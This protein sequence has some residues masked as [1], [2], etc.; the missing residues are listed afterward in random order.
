MRTEPAGER[1]ETGSGNTDIS[2]RN[3]QLSAQEVQIGDIVRLE[4]L[5]LDCQGVE[6]GARRGGPVR[7]AEANARLIV[8]ESS[9]NRFLSLK[10][11][12]EVRELQV[13]I[14]NGKVRITGRYMLLG[15]IPVPFTLTAVPEI[16]GGARLRLDPKQMSLIGAPIPGVATQMIGDR[17]NAYLSRT[18]D[19]TRLPIA[20][21][22]TGLTAETGRLILTATASLDLRPNVSV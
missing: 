19:A 5:R 2:I 1:Q 3:A 18:L 20:L 22:L 4:E 17:V 7:I 10:P 9:L 11:D 14:L 12:D 13:A 21:R 6:I 16:E 15:R 8:S